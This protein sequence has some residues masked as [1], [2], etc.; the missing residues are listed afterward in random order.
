MSG[1]TLVLMD[2]CS[3][4]RIEGVQSFMG[5]DASG[6]FGLKRGHVRFLTRLAAG[7][8]RFGLA[9]DGFRYLAMSPAVLRFEADVL[10]LHTRRYVLEDDYARLL[11]A[12]DEAD[13]LEDQKLLSTKRSAD[14]LERALLKRIWESGS[15]KLDV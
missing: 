12:L 9:D 1:F 7:L 8:C 4:R 13:W 14:Q 10:C 15:G 2:R 6:S 3:I 11:G 5:E